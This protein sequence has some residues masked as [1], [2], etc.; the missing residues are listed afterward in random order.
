MSLR[1]PLRAVRAHL[2][3]AINQTALSI[4]CDYRTGSRQIWVQISN[5]N[6]PPVTRVQNN[7]RISKCRCDSELKVV[8]ND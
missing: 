7:R 3:S 5:T 2:R 4:G 8:S 1:L 6:G